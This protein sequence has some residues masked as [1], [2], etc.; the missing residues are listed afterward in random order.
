STKLTQHANYCYHRSFSSWIHLSRL[1]TKR[2]PPLHSRVSAFWNRRSVR[3][4]TLCLQLS[5]RGI[6]APTDFGGPAREQSLRPAR[7]RPARSGHRQHSALSPID[8]SGRSATGSRRDGAVD[9]RFSERPLGLR[10]PLAAACPS[11]NT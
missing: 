4:R 10:G 11:V 9:R 6:S 2:L 5:G 3:R 1:R 7:P 8:G